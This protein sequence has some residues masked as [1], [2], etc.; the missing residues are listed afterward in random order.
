MDNGISI[1]IITAGIRND[2]SNCIDSLSNQLSIF[3]ELI[4][5]EN[6]NA[7][8]L[9][10]VITTYSQKVKFPIKYI[11]ESNIGY[12]FA[13]NIG[14]KKSTHR[15]ISFIDDD[16]VA[17]N[18]W[19]IQIKK[20]I[21]LHTKT[22]VIVGQS[23]PIDNNNPYSFI[24]F[25]LDY[26]WKLQ[27]RIN[28]RIVDFATLDT[29]NITYNKQFLLQKGVKFNTLFNLGGEDIDL[30]YQLKKL[31][32]KAIY[33]PNIIIRHKNPTNIKDFISKIIRNQKSEILLNKIWKNLTH[34]KPQT[35]FI[36]KISHYVNIFNYPK[37]QIFGLYYSFF[38]FSLLN[39]FVKT[40]IIVNNTWFTLQYKKPYIVCQK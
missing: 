10:K 15:W 38:L 9:R 18:N 11:H 32:A 33:S 6:N 19:L 4:I 29:K 23:K 26:D 5:V 36:F 14:I 20:C 34:H 12:S 17:D 39:K 25:I 31:G 1:I 3:D 27:G 24:I 35:K 30:G 22:H 40:L 16:C 7:P 8:I 2:I 28:S 13:R 37:K 21:K